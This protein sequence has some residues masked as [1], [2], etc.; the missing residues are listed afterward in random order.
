MNREHLH[1]LR[2]QLHHLRGR[3]EMGHEMDQVSKDDVAHAQVLAL[4]LIAEC[5]H[6]I[7]FEGIST[8]D[9]NAV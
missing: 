2:L 4:V 9:P 7:A 3:V 8:Y 1:Q 6:K 5:L